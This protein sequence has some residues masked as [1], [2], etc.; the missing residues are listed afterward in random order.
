MEEKRAIYSRFL[1]LN[2]H[3]IGASPTAVAHVRFYEADM[4]YNGAFIAMGIEDILGEERL[5][6][7]SDLVRWLLRQ[8]ST[9]DCRTQKI[10]A[11]VFDS[12][13]VLSDVLRVA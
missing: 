6:Q 9:Y 5:N 10:L 12:E 4:N 1:A 2:S 13:I 11:L 3:K 7:Q 8:L